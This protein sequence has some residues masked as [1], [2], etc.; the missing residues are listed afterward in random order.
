MAGDRQR[1]HIGDDPAEDALDGGR[2]AEADRVGEDDRIGAG[3][4]GLASDMAHPILVHR[5]LDRTAEGGG[6]PASDAW[7]PIGRRLMAQRHDAAEIVDRL[8]RAAADIGAIVPVADRQHEIHLVHAPRQAALRPAKVRN[9]GRHGKAGQAQR[10][11]HH[12]FDV[13]ELR[14][15]FG[16]DEGAYLDFAHPGGIFG[17]EPG[18]LVLGRQDLGEALQP[19]AQADFADKGRFAHLHLPLLP[20]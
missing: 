5:P 20:R 2:L 9:Q 8:G 3:L 13:G 11:A 7:A 4:G 17:V 10:V 18:D 12:R 19:V 15:Q 1:R 14:Q 16:R 6:E